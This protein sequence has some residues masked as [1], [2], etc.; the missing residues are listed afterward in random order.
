MSTKKV[1]TISGISILL[2]IL[3]EIFF[4]HPQH[5]LYWWDTFIG[6]DVIYGFFGCLLLIVFSKGL[7]RHLVQRDENYYDGGEDNDD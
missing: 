4:V 5:A 6:F 2:T 7:I 3:V 1:L